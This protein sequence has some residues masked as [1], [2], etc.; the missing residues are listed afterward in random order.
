MTNQYYKQVDNYYDF[1]SKDI[2]LKNI[3]KKDIVD[4]C[5]ISDVT[6][7]KSLALLMSY[8]NYLIPTKKLYQKY[9][10]LRDC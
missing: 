9:L 3:D 4:K 6:I 2:Q 5:D 10:E 1:P 8:K 7:N